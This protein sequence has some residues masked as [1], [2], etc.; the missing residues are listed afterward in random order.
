VLILHAADLHLSEAERDYTFPILDEIV[1]IAQREEAGLLLFAGDMFDSFQD[2]ERLHGELRTRLECLRPACR[3]LM[4]AGNHEHLRAPEAAVDAMRRMSFGRAQL[5]SQEPFQVVPPEG[6]SGVEVVGLPHRLRYTDYLTWA[7][8]PPAA[9]RARVVLAHAALTGASYLGPDPEEAPSVMDVDLLE[10]LGADYAA[11]GHLHTPKTVKV[12][13]VT[14]CYPGSAR[15][16]RKGEAGPRGVSLV[17]VGQGPLRL[18]R[19]RLATA[20]EYR[21]VPVELGLEG[22]APDLDRAAAGWGPRDAVD[23][24]LSGLVEDEHAAERTRAALEIRYRGRV[25]LLEVRLASVSSIAGISRNALAARYLELWRAREA[26]IEAAHGPE[27]AR[28]V[29]RAGLDKIKTILE[30]RKQVSA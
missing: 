30:T 6:E 15:V 3:V 4:V 21:L 7:V 20:G 23:I 11:M 14:V 22:D 19:V 9:G 27:V 12:G 13:G 16:W 28:R 5:L 17:N 1:G 29:L 8:P 26:E 25:R 2:L 18:R 24:E 10:R